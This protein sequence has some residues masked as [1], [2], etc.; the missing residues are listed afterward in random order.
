[1]LLFLYAGSGERPR[2]SLC[3]RYCKENWAEGQ[4]SFCVSC[5]RHHKYLPS[6]YSRPLFPKKAVCVCRQLPARGRGVEMCPF[7]YRQSWDEG[8]F[9][10]GP[11]T[12]A[13]IDIVY[14]SFSSGRKIWCREQVLSWKG[15]RNT[16]FTTFNTRVATFLG[17]KFKLIGIYGSEWKWTEIDW[18]LWVRL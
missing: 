1:M 15:A 14:S 3:W 18:N 16:H 10:P 5:E 7:P 13:E 11:V 8:D 6:A 2:L 12:H 9:H 17:N 4:C